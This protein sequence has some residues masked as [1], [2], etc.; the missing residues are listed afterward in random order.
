MSSGSS[1]FIFPPTLLFQKTGKKMGK[2][3]KITK[4]FYT[5][6]DLDRFKPSKSSDVQKSP[7]F[8]KKWLKKIF[9]TFFQRQKMG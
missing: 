9:L 5:L 7:D 2:K 6:A 8:Y 1:V 3:C 4:K